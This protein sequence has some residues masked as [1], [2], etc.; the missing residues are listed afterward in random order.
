MPSNILPWLTVIAQ[1]VALGRV[2]QTEISQMVRAARGKTDVDTE[3]EDYA[4]LEEVGL[5]I[6]I[7]QAKARAEAGIVIT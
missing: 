4:L 5:L 7:E 1:L 2:T 6:E 3:N